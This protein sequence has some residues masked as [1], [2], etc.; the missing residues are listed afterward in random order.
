MPVSVEANWQFTTP[1]R[2]SIRK[3]R[4]VGTT[5]V[6]RSRSRIARHDY[7]N[8]TETDRANGRPA[9]SFGDG[10]KWIRKTR[11][12]NPSTGKATQRLVLSLN[13]SYSYFAGDSGTAVSPCRGENTPTPTRTS[14]DPRDGVNTITATRSIAMRHVNFGG[15]GADKQTWSRQYAPVRIQARP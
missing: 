1:S 14:H 7:N 8:S 12:C 4:P 5:A 3:L 11:C 15:G 6:G 13:M 2:S 9:S 10:P